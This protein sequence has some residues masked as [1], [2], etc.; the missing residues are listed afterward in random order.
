MN[1]RN[2][3]LL[4]ALTLFAIPSFAQVQPRQLMV[5][6]EVDDGG[7]WSG[8][9]TVQQGRYLDNPCTAV[10]DLVWVNYEA[11]ADGLQPEDGVQRYQFA[12]NT[13]MAGSYA[14]SGTSDADIAYGTTFSTRK[15]HKVNTPDDFHVVTVITFNPVTEAMTLTLETACG[16]GLPD[17]LQ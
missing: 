1:K 2:W 3:L 10:Q 6:R 9:T 7:G 5:D 12:E 15:Y 13:S 16:N 8:S 4:A 17:S 14:A 11:Y